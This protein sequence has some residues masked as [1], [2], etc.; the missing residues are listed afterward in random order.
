MIELEDYR[1]VTEHR[2]TVVAVTIVTGL[3]VNV[4]HA[5]RSSPD[6]IADRHEGDGVVGL[7]VAHDLKVFRPQ[8][9]CSPCVRWA[10]A[11]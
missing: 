6:L 10:A 5:V 2:P 8:H 7:A 11:P 1:T 3:E 4:P 9:A